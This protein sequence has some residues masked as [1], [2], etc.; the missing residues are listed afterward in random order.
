MVVVVAVIAAGVVG[1]SLVRRTFP[2]TTGQITVPGLSNSVTVI[3]DARGVPQ[4]YADNALDLFRAQGYVSA[5]DRFF[6]MDLRRHITAGR[7]SELVGSAG[8]ETD[9]VVRT[10]GWR[11]V[12]EQ[13]LLLISP[14][15]RSYLDAYAQGVNDYLHQAGDASNIAL[16]YSVLGLQHPGY[17]PQDWTAVDSLS[18]LEAMA[19]DLRGDYDNELTRALLAPTVS[20]SQ[21]A[22]LYPTY[23][24]DTHAPILSSADWVPGRAASS[25]SAAAPTAAPT[26]ATTT[27][28]TTAATHA[29]TTPNPST[30]PRPA[31][32]AATVPRPSAELVSTALSTVWSNAQATLAAVPSLLGRGDGIGSNSWVVGPGLSST[33]K[34]LLANDPHLQVG[35]PGIWTQVGLHCRSVGTA[36]P[37]DVSGFAFSGLPGVVIGHNAKIA[38][39]FTNLGPDVSDFYLE[40]VSGSTYQRDGEQVPLTVRHETISVAGGADVPITIR[41]TVHGPIISDVI[42]SL[43][44]VGANP[45]V[46][47]KPVKATYAVSLAWTGLIPNR[48]ADAIFA[49]DSATDFGSFR[50]AARL[51]AVPAQNLIYADTSGNIGY[52]APGMIPVRRS[53]TPGAPPGYWPAPGWDSRYDWT[54]WVPFDQMPYVYNP[55]EGFIVTANQAVTATSTP[56]LTTEWDYGFRSQRIRDLISSHTKITPQDMAAIQLDTYDSF[57]PTLVQALLKV[58]LSKD[59]FTRSAQDLLR[60]WNYTQPADKSRSS[61]SAAY[62]NAVWAKILQYT[63][64]DQAGL[65]PDGGSRW[66]VVV[67][68]LLKDPTNA[69]WDDKTTPG[70]VENE[71]E[72]LRR[73]LVDARLELTEELGKDPVTW[74]WG[75][76]HTVTLTHQVMGDPSV[77]QLVRDVFDRGPIA[78]P[79]GSSVV[80]AMGWDASSSFAVDWG[81]SMRMVVDLGD[82][83]ASRWVNQ[84][85]ESGHPF[86]SNYDDQIDAWATGS[87]FPWPFTRSAVTSAAVDTL[88]MVP[89]GS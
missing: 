47:G 83:D 12:A 86:S 3:R 28:T 57:A 74:R 16:E 75:R 31:G 84:T 58:D 65:S 19:W 15:T 6:E 54:G 88:T 79:G 60:G 22:L 68:Q 89:G 87:T 13:E 72:I 24:F 21:L 2:Q 5:Q 14:T 44:K 9:K 29:A 25:S 70:V 85:G 63:F 32:S 49:L 35:I 4:I 52:Q 7:L 78:V 34:P 27:A 67:T 55:P 38:W 39:G 37:F 76:L 10:L 41:S 53:S 71:S 20:A 46:A 64:G 59:S 33:G 36:C 43:A 62:F 61:A 30:A 66:M 42:D 69:W 81:P 17:Q 8:V 11:Q 77:P 73:A 40:K 45:T 80:D 82:L 26:A 56:F 48:T 1:T 51:F 50:Q 23:P 18:W